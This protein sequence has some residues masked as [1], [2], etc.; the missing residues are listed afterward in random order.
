MSTTV[1]IVCEIEVTVDTWDSKSSFDNLAKAAV[2]E[3]SQKLANIAQE[4]GDLR[5]L[6]VKEVRFVTHSIPWEKP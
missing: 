6:G 5:L 1:R 2:R 3:G 4:S